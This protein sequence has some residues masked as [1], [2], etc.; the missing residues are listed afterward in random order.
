MYF[1]IA[2]LSLFVFSFLLS[3]EEPHSPALRCTVVVLGVVSWLLSE[4]A[5]TESQCD[6]NVTRCSRFLLPPMKSVR[7]RVRAM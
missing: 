1:L 2:A 5:P 4:V 6:S 3:R 7:I